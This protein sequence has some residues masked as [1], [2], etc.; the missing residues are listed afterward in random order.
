MQQAMRHDAGVLTGARKVCLRRI[1]DICV[2][3]ARRT[4]ISNFW[5]LLGTRESSVY[6]H[7]KGTS[8]LE[9]P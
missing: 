3:K 2:Q 7:Y 9:K 6:I 1:L 8:Y 4:K 5:I